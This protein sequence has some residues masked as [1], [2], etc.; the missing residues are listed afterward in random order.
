[1]TSSRHYA[2]LL[3]AAVL[4]APVAAFAQDADSDTVPDASD[5]FPCDA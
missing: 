1:M 4:A 3:G 2:F 5:A